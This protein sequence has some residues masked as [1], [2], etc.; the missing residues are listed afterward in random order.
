MRLGYSL[1][2]M[3]KV[4]IE[5][6]LPALAKMGYQGVELAV[7]PGWNTE[8]ARLDGATRL[9]IRQLLAETGLDLT[10]VAGHTSMLEMDSAKNEA[11]MRSLREA[12][13]LSAELHQVGH[14]AI[15]ASLVGGRPE[16]WLPLRSM[17]AERIRTLGEYAAQRGVILAIE[18]HCG[19]ALDLP[20]KAVWLFEQVSHPAVRMNF[21]ISHMDVMG[22]GI[23]ECVPIMAP[24]AVHT[25]VKDQT[26]RYPNHIFLT[27]GEGPFDF[28]H[29]LRA[30]QSTGYN[31]YIVVEVSVMVQRRPDYDPLAHAAL[32]YRTLDRAFKAVGINRES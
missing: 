4:P 17:L 23:D 16:D 29:Y 1:W 2:G 18:P 6:S 15:M 3:P 26:G 11:N 25:H 12:I 21:D 8:L 10:A 13:D 31:G 5:E 14:P 30:M 22:I 24:L 32:G 27:P 9:R 7:T 19:T 20:D 28:V